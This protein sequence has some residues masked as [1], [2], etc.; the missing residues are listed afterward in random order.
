VAVG[1]V[2]GLESHLLYSTFILEFDGANE[3]ARLISNFNYS[4]IKS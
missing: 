1:H 3:G 4:F 2:V